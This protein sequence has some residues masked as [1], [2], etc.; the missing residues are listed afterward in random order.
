MSLSARPALHRNFHR[1]AW[2]AMIMT[3]STIMF[4]AF[5]RL[6]DAGLS[7]PDWPTCY[8]QA[9]WPQHVEETI[10]HPA[11]EIRPL[12]THK[13]WREQVHRFLAGA[14]GIE[15]L[16][17][18]LLATRK[19]RFGSTAVVTAC[20]LVAAGIPLYMMGW[21]GTAS[22]LALI[23]E[24]VLLIAA[25]RWS[26]IDLARAALLTLAVVIFQ[27]LLG[28]WTV[29]LL[30]KPIVVMGHLLGGMLMFGLL[31]WMAWRATH[32]PITLAEAPKLKWL[33]RIGVAVLVTQIALGGW[34]SANYAALACGGGSA[35]LD[36]F[37][38]CANQW[39]PQH[40]FVEGFTLWRG[41]G[42]DYEGGVL[43]GA[44]RI[45]IQMAHRLFAVVVALY[46]LWLGV[47]LFRLP[48]MRG[49]ASALIALLVLQVTLGILNV[50][51]ALPLEVAVAH[52][53]VAVALLFV[54]V[55]LLARLRAPD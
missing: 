12:E 53:G 41:I 11:A 38:R 27:A 30:L 33:L 9:T 34:V 28:M 52:N 42:V 16:T 51:L 46:L 22:V 39:W 14:L 17:L 49:W 10:G 26:N 21:H 19:R 1:L 3:A 54:L 4:G 32:M 43:D 45:A 5:V 37:P 18:A 8:G 20:V 35:S 24:A 15:I 50:K 25:L 29:T 6:S 40:N 36:N 55:S 13:A 47:R 48:S 31:V 23:G 44:S 7:C 2:F